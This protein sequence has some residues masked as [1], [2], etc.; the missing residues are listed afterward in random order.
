VPPAGGISPK[1]AGFG[2]RFFFEQQ[3]VIPAKAVI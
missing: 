1:T 2:L 3:P